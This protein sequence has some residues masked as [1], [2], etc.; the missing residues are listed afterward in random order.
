MTRSR[1]R[2]EDITA[3]DCCGNV[4]LP[5]GRIEWSRGGGVIGDR[6]DQAL[7]LRRIFVFQERSRRSE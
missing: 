3:N 1:Q 4:S 7:A 6:H 5:P 2:D